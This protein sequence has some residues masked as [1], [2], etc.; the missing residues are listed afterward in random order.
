VLLVDEAYLHFSEAPS[1][2]GLAATRDDVVVMRTFSKLFGM[3]GMRLGLTFAAPDLHARMN[4]YDGQ[5]VTATLPMPAV[6]CGN[7]AYTM[8]PQIAARRAE[9]VATRERTIATLTGRGITVHPGS[10]ANMIMVDWKTRPAPEMQRALLEQHKVQIGRNWPIW[11]TVSRVTIGSPEE[12]D[13]FCTAAQQ[14]I[15]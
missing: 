3:A 1:A 7:A 15:A 4:R 12:M 9:M 5:Q 6:A 8:A 2:I 11:P 10:Q 14:V 13:A